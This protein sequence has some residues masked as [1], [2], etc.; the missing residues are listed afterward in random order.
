MA[1]FHCFPLLVPE[2]RFR[3]WALATQDRAIRVKRGDAGYWS[4]SPVPAVTRAC[5][6][7]RKHCS[8][9]KSFIV[10]SKERYIWVNFDY[11]ILHVRG[12]IFWGLAR[13]PVGYIKHLRIELVDDDGKDTEED[14]FNHHLAE[15]RD[16]P[17]LKTVDL[18]VLRELSA[19]APQHLEDGYFRTCDESVEIRIANIST[20]EWIDNG[21]AGPY[22]DYIESS[23]GEDLD[24]M[25]RVVD[26]DDEE[27]VRERIED[28]KQLQMP[29][30]RLNLDYQ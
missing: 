19:Y 21:T 2:L 12:T 15:L 11:D 1:T 9:Q 7:S 13:L 27:F 26:W 10:A 8:F 23:G 18:L 14:W 6:E 24:A 22:R 3:I 28:I 4:P 17:K 30:P 16:F 20:G 25:T 29:R 5:H